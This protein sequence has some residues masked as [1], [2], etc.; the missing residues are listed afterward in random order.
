MRNRTST[1]QRGFT[2]IEVLIALA[3]VTIISLTLLGSLGPWLDFKHELDTQSKL[4]DI[5][6]GITAYYTANAMA[7][8][9][10]PATELKPFTPSTVLVGKSCAPQV[11]AFEAVSSYM[12]NSAQYLSVD[13]YKQAWCV[14]VSPPLVAT[15]DGTQLWYRNIAFVSPG[16]N[17]KIDPGTSM[18]AAGTLTLGGDDKGVLIAGYPIEQ[19]KLTDTL[20]RMNTVAQAYGT[21][22]TS[23]YL[24]YPDRDVTR[25]YFSTAWDSAGTVP[26]TG[27]N[28]APASS[29]LSSLGLTPTDTLSGWETN[30]AIQVG[31]DTE[32]AAGVT[33]RS[34]DTTGTGSLPYTALLRAQV[35]TPGST[36]TYTAIS[37]SGSY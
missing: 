33:V 32:S 6:Q 36:P 28:W 7:I 27:G 26:S 20:R 12:S 13:G 29:A 9:S 17:G 16:R 10:D 8:D 5:Q 11:A 1:P 2:L 21:Y 22:F 18:S 30:N 23:R 31:N 4:S 24:A 34:P 3:L 37:V 25:D 14:F 35:P 19:Q 15:A